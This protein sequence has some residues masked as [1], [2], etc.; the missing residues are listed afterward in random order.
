[1]A[2]PGWLAA[3]PAAWTA[4]APRGWP[5]P[6]P[7]AWAG[8][9]PGGPGTPGCPSPATGPS[10]LPPD[11]AAGAKWLK[12]FYDELVPA[13]RAADP[14]HPVFYEDFL[15]T[16]FGYH[17]TLGDAAR[18]RAASRRRPSSAPRPGP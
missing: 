6:A 7:A 2:P 8:P 9:P 13:L 14:R 4:V 15:T 11:P 16:A 10:R 5:G 1:M 17:S 3:A 12:P 18:L